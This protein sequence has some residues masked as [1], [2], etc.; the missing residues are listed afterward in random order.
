MLCVGVLN[1]NGSYWSTKT[2]K[3]R[4]A[5]VPGSTSARGSNYASNNPKYSKQ[6]LTPYF[7]SSKNNSL[8]RLMAE[9]INVRVWI[10]VTRDLNDEEQYPCPLNYLECNKANVRVLQKIVISIPF[11]YSIR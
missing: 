4:G 1:V 9:Q 2:N 5:A 3:P 10:A 11:N 8:K 7:G 6:D